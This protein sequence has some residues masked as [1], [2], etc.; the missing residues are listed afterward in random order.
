MF[1]SM[2]VFIDN[3]CVQAELKALEHLYTMRDDE[4]ISRNMQS[5][6]PDYQKM[7]LAIQNLRVN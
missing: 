5:P 6:V 4:D 2:L 7:N 1:L 3:A